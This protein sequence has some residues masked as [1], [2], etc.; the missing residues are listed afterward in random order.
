MTSFISQ[1][2]YSPTASISEIASK[3]SAP[4]TNLAA[5]LAAN[6]QLV[7]DYEK[8]SGSGVDKVK[9]GVG[10]A[11]ALAFVAGLALVYRHSSATPNSSAEYMKGYRAGMRRCG[12]Y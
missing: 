1:L 9:A 5:K 8:S 6:P 11:I 2:S 7:L 10:V 12:R 3:F 4:T